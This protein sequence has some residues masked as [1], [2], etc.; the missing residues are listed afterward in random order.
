M[1]RFITLL[2]IMAVV[3]MPLALTLIPRLQKALLSMLLLSPQGARLEAPATPPEDP[4]PQLPPLSALERLPSLEIATKWGKLQRAVRKE[5]IAKMHD[6]ALSPTL[7]KRYQVI[8]DETRNRMDLVTEIVLAHDTNL[9]EC[10]RRY[11][12][13]RL[14]GF[15]AYWTGRWPPPVPFELIPGIEYCPF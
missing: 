1:R 5:A 9:D 15:N 4:Y 10:T 8:A 3:L 7:R 14:Q 12:I 11:A 2:A 13:G 6:W